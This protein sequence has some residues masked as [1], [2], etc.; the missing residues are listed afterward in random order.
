MIG[1]PPASRTPAR[2]LARLTGGRAGPTLLVVAGIHG[3]EPAGLIAAERVVSRLAS[4]TA[5]MAGE[6]RVLRGN[7]RALRERKRYLSRDLNR[8][9]S[10]AHL[11]GLRARG[12]DGLAPE[13][14]EQLELLDAIDAAIDAASGPVVFLDLHTTS[15]EGIPFAMV[16]R[17]EEARIFALHFPLPVIQGLLEILDG[18]LLEYMSERGC[19]CVGVEGGQSSS[20]TS[21]RRHEAVLWIALAAAG[22]LPEEQVPDLG[23]H[24][25]LLRAARANLPHVMEVVHRH[26][27]R[28]DDGFLMEAGFENIQAIEAGRLLARDRRGAIRAPEDGLLLLPLYQGLGDDGFFLGREVRPD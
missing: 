18:V 20:E 4:E 27:I 11:A 24:R 12:S 23:H 3:N 28:P 13:D 26:A 19:V 5:G 14:L 21:V 1:A 15:A 16:G 6:L 17:R 22:L 7:V 10:A 25:E 2:E 8:R 9:W